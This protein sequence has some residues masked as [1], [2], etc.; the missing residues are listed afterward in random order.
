M[1]VYPITIV[2]MVGFVGAIIVFGVITNLIGALAGP[3]GSLSKQFPAQAIAE[4]ADRGET[5]FALTRQ[6]I[7]GLSKTSTGLRKGMVWFGGLF[8][9]VLGVTMLLALFGMLGGGLGQGLWAIMIITTLGFYTLAMVWLGWRF[10][11]MPFPQQVNFAADDE[12]LHLRRISDVITRYPWISVPWGAIGEFQMLDGG[13]RVSFPIGHRWA[14][15]MSDVLARELRVRRAMQGSA[16]LPSIAPAATNAPPEWS[17]DDAVIGEGGISSG[18]IQP[19]RD[20]PR[21]WP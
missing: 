19:E 10:L 21:R 12:F 9:M 3:W 8:W 20:R 11:K 2:L 1:Q 6:P 17:G 5:W 18:P 15:T 7:V 14:Y 16:T 13:A 4:G